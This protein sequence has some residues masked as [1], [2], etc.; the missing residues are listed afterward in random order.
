MSGNLNFSS[1]YAFLALLPSWQSII[2]SPGRHHHELPFCLSSTS[3][4]PSVPSVMDVA[5]EASANQQ[6]FVA[7]R[8]LNLGI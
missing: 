2:T 4:V 1:F 3:I 6:L 5:S 7:R 8:R